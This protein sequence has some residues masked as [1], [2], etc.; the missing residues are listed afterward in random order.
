MKKK[1]T[2]ERPNQQ[3]GNKGARES[4][5][6]LLLLLSLGLMLLTQTG[7]GLLAGRE[8]K[9]AEYP[10]SQLKRGT[11]ATTVSTAG[12]TSFTQKIQ[13]NFGS[14]GTVERVLVERGQPVRKGQVLS[15]LDTLDLEV[16]VQQARQNLL[17]AQKALADYQDQFSPGEVARVKAT[18]ADAT[19]IQEASQDAYS[20]TKAPTEPE[21]NR[22]RIAVANARV[23][24]QTAQSELN[25]AIA[26]AQA[27]LEKAQRTLAATQ[28]DWAN[29]VDQASRKIPNLE[30]T[31]RDKLEK[32]YRSYPVTREDLKRSPAE[33]LPPGSY[34]ASSVQDAW[35]TLLDAR[36]SLESLSQ[37]AQREIAAAQD[38]VRKAQDN[39][40][41][42]LPPKGILLEAK[43]AQLELAKA[44]LSEAEKNLATLL[45]GGDPLVLLERASQVERAKAS[46]LKAEEELTRMLRG[47]DPYQNESLKIAVES[48]QT[49][50]RKAESNLAKASLT[51]PFDGVVATVNIEAGQIIGASAAAIV[52]VDPTAVE[53]TASV[54]EVDVAQL[55]VGQAVTLTL[56]ALQGMTMGGQVKS[57][58][59]VAKVQQG[60][61]SYDVII[62][63]QDQ[64]SAGGTP[65]RQGFLQGLAELTPEQR[66]RLQERL[67]DGTA[68]QGQNQRQDGGGRAGR[69]GALGSAALMIREGMTVSARITIQQKENV[70]LLP[71]RAARTAQ[72]KRVVDVL[73]NGKP[74]A[75][76]V[77][78][79]LTNEQY[80][81]VL[82]GLQEGDTVVLPT[83]TT[84]QPNLG[85]GGFGGPGG[86][87][88]IR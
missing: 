85:S 46:L 74:V 63:L 14:S 4:S 31:Y 48:A 54:D 41:L 22:A 86:L 17:K 2:A 27:A 34:V 78:L 87:R 51:A 8:A 60:V 50:L 18:V 84:R 10:T 5:L 25:S 55:R 42:T 62:T 77:R 61:V 47:P 16:A 37:Q 52:V 71:V 29:K 88:G 11:L 69:P 40:D 36:R 81:E 23:A 7:C 80:A 67:Q 75:R 68:R 82:E 6:T 56:D 38:A 35:D 58:A 72:G 20:K 49:N 57:I 1:N 83:V 21:L 19:A 45:S 79:G 53:V 76:E 65:A 66:Q 73:V 39:L 59:P 12:S 44:N 64:T 15:T 33:I 32:F 70:I 28:L 26:D 24:V 13:L 30:D 3:I 43:Q 9:A